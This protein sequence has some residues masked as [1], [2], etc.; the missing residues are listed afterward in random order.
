MK[1]HRLAF[2]A[3]ALAMVCAPAMAQGSFTM[4]FDGIP[5]AVPA[6]PQPDQTFGSAVLGYYNGDPGFGRT[7]NKAWDVTFSDEA[8]AICAQFNDEDCKGNFPTPPSGNS[9]V[10]SV[11]TSSFTFF[12]SPGLYVSSLSFYYTDA[13]SSSNPG[14]RLFSGSTELLTLALTPCPGGFCP[15]REFEVPQ[16]DLAGLPV[17]AVAFLG[18]PN[19][20]AFDNVSVTTTP[21]PEPSTY[22]LM[23]GGLALLAGLARRRAR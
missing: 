18:T 7:G 1:P 4:D 21:I 17:T 13:G 23:L 22:A 2:G 12:V 10:G 9:A 11:S 16:S 6:P 5:L 14:V 20:V 15:W 8:L 19:A 3:L